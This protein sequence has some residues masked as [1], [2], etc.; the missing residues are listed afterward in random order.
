[1]M[2]DS[3]VASRGDLPCCRTGLAADIHLRASR[4][5][6]PMSSAMLSA[7][8]IAVVSY[9]TTAQAQPADG[10]AGMLPYRDGAPRFVP[11]QASQR[12]SGL[13]KPYRIPEETPVGSGPG[14]DPLAIKAGTFNLLSCSY[15][16]PDR[17]AN[18]DSRVSETWAFWWPPA[19][20]ITPREVTSIPET[21]SGGFLVDLA[22][23]RCPET[24]GEARALAMRPARQ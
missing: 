17:R 21:Y 9:T 5:S 8:A 4:R 6:V 12:T 1:M 13:V 7:F 3:T 16:I 18:D 10:G 14:V 22:L 19:P 20:A 11:R 15:S 2:P 24:L 23:K